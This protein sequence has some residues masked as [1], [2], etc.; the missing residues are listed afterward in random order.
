MPGAG[1]RRASVLDRAALRAGDRMRGP[2]LLEGGDH[3]CL[4]PP[5]ARARVDAWGNLE[6]AL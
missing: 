1:A 2:C 6:V 4:L 5:G 3:T